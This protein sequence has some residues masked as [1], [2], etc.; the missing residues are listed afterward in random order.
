LAGLG[1]VPVAATIAAA[2]MNPPDSGVLTY[3]MTTFVGG[4]S[5]GYGGILPIAQRILF[6]LAAIEIVFA[7]LWWALKGENFIVPLIQK[8][9]LIGVF[10]AFLL[11]GPLNWATL[12][13]GVMRGFVATGQAAG[14]GAGNVN[15]FSDP[16]AIIDLADALTIQ[17]EQEIHAL[18]MLAVGQQIMFGL[19]YLLIYLTFFILAI[20][21][22]IAILEYYL[23]ATL[24]MAL[25]PFG[26]NKYTAFLSEKAFGAVVS[27]GVKLMVLAFIIT[28]AAPVMVGLNLP[29][30]PTLEQAYMCLLAAMT[31]AFLAWKAP[32]VAAGLFAGGPSLTAAHSLGTAAVGARLL[33]GGGAGGRASSFFGF[34]KAAGQVGGGLKAITR[35]AGALAGGASGGAAMASLGGATRTGMLLGATRG[36]TTVVGSAAAR[37]VMAG[38]QALRGAWET[39]RV[40][41]FQTSTGIRGTRS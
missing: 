34:G 19:V 9:M 41:G 12:M 6:L 18:P 38:T 37:P 29:P 28:V 22:V 20:Q 39:G 3:L 11:P 21:V 17:I 14:G 16:S 40:A 35:G 27:H 4:F 5:S 30:N 2:G 36:A 13:T 8:T 10:A 33:M 32:D 15:W 7:G 26:V 24:A 1:F 31:L 23:I 25:V